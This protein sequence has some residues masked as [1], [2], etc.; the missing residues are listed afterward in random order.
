[1]RKV[2]SSSSAASLLPS[3]SLSLSLL[4]LPKSKKYY[5]DGFLQI[6]TRLRTKMTGTRVVVD[7]GAS[8]GGGGENGKRKKA[9]IFLLGCFG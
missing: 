5:N 4:D 2:L 9:C 3:T 8:G 7:G 6:S 1:M